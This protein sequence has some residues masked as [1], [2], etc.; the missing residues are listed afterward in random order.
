MD[1]VDEK[2]PGTSSPKVDKEKKSFDEMTSDEMA[3]AIVQVVDYITDKK[4]EKADFNKTLIG[5]IVRVKDAKN[6]QYEIKLEDG[7]KIV[8]YDNNEWGLLATG[9]TVQ[10][11]SSQNG[12]ERDNVIIRTVGREKTIAC[13]KATMTKPE[14][15]KY[16][17]ITEEYKD[18]SILTYYI[19]LNDDEDEAIAIQKPDGSV[20]SLEGFDF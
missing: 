12:Q 14:D 2:K 1:K 4:I 11:L 7:G 13:M 3:D 6:H 10:I 17:I 16:Y 19:H 8:A 18:G 20:I 5:K 9:S 15:Q